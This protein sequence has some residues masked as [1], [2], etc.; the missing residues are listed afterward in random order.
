MIQV[1]KCPS[2][3]STLSDEG[4]AEPT[5]T[6]QFCGSTVIV[7][8]ELRPKPEAA[9]ASS[10]PSS[11]LLSSALEL[12]EA[13]TGLPLDKLAEL[14]RLIS[15]GQKIEAVK[16]YREITGVGLKEAKDAVEAMEAGRPVT[17][18][19]F[20]LETPAVTDASQDPRVGEMVQLIYDN[21]KIEAIKLYREI[22]DTGLK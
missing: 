13:L 1:F 7:P 21:R 9:P 3:G 19:N 14:K 6:C 2:C 15:S 10:E 18:A 22:F 4:G 8:E 20:K 17:V 11:T 5:I 16:L 12:G